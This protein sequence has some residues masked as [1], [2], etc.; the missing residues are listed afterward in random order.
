MSASDESHEAREEGKTLL[1]KIFNNILENPLNEKYHN[2][3]AI[4][5]G[6]RLSHCFMNILENAGFYMSNNQRLI[7]DKSKLNELRN[8]RDLLLNEKSYHELLN[9]LIEIG[10]N[11]EP[12]SIALSQCNNDINESI[13]LLVNQQLLYGLKNVLFDS[14]NSQNTQKLKEIATKYT[15][16]KPVSMSSAYMLDG[17]KINSQ[18]DEKCNSITECKSLHKIC[19]V[20][21]RYHLFV[22][23]QRYNEDHLIIQQLENE[24]FCAEEA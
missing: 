13:K 10:F 21:Q 2:L 6:K 9:E 14:N 11:E 20:L 1:L 23:H 15:D 8:M 18:N 19:D 3:N 16:I 24:G 17:M 4:K 5:V 22:E 12:S 7:F